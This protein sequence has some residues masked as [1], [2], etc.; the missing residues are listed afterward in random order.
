MD[1]QEFEN[2]MS[3]L[4]HLR[5]EWSMAVE[6]Y[7]EDFYYGP[8]TKLTGAFRKILEEVKDLL[9]DSI[10]E[11]SIVTAIVGSFPQVYR[12]LHEKYRSDP[13]IAAACVFWLTPADLPE[14]LLNNAKFIRRIYYINPRVL[15]RE[16]VNRFID[17][18][19][20]QLQHISKDE[21]F[22]QNIPD[23]WE[24]DR[25]FW[26]QAVKV[27]GMSIHFL[28][29]EFWLDREIALEAVNQTG[30]AMK[31]LHPVFQR[32]P[33]IVRLAIEN[34]EVA[35]QYANPE[36]FDKDPWLK[37]KKGLLETY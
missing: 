4:D 18:R 31:Y 22:V 33:E 29:R 35:A 27:N 21:Y 24:K 17:D 15:T 23:S 19:E 12:D 5:E 6:A 10:E 16:L 32:D 36:V 30:W 7:G 3:W 14:S 9:N 25:E 26:I 37:G 2:R 28:P 34:N 1:N 11:P 8:D 13:E 20:K